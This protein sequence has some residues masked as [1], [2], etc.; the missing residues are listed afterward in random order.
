MG[1]ER[2]RI[3]S[4]LAHSVLSVKR[5]MLLRHDDAHASS[6][7]EWLENSNDCVCSTERLLRIMKCS[8]LYNVYSGLV[9]LMTYMTHTLNP[10][11]RAGER[12]FIHCK[13][14]LVLSFR[15]EKSAPAVITFL[16]SASFYLV[17]VN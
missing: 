16:G 12:G 10:F 2:S 13:F 9:S 5:V 6:P 7:R 15:K 3:H 1:S 4:P 8:L 17:R 14:S 11:E